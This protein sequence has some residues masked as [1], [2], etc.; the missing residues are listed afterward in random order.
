[1]KAILTTTSNRSNPPL[2]ANS[3]PASRPARQFGPPWGRW[4]HLRSP[5]TQRHKKAPRK[6]PIFTQHSPVDFFSGGKTEY[7]RK[8][9][10]Y[11]SGL[12]HSILKNWGFIGGKSKHFC[13]FSFL[14]LVPLRE[15]SYVQLILFSYTTS[16]SLSI[17]WLRGYPPFIQLQVASSPMLVGDSNSVGMGISVGDDLRLRSFE[18]DDPYGYGLSAYLRFPWWNLHVNRLCHFLFPG[19][20]L[21]NGCFSKNFMDAKP[22]FWP[23]ETTPFWAPHTKA[24]EMMPL[25]ILGRYKTQSCVCNAKSVPLHLPHY[26]LNCDQNKFGRATAV[27]EIW[28]KSV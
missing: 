12:M 7:R 24:E 20:S 5:T 6:L 11:T 16:F 13:D 2:I 15:I 22:Y 21:V 27:R 17:F 23:Q 4:S 28:Y 3:P 1:M 14:N 19:E 18:S 8:D 26:S 10:S 9:T 25:D